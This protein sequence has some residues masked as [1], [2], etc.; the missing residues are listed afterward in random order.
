MLQDCFGC[1][2]TVYNFHFA[3]VKLAVDSDIA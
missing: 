3:Y 1:Q 2:R